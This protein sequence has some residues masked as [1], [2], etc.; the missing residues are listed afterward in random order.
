MKRYLEYCFMATLAI[1]LVPVNMYGSPGSG[2]RPDDPSFPTKAEMMGWISDLSTI[3]NN[4]LPGT[5]TDD[6]AREYLIGKF[7]DIGLANVREEIIDYHDGFLYYFASNWGLTVNGQPIPSMY[8]PNTQPTGPG[9]IS[10][11]VVYVGTSV[12]PDEDVAGKIVL[13]DIEMFVLSLDVLRFFAY[14]GY[15]PRNTTLGLEHVAPW[16]RENF[17]GRDYITEQI[18]LGVY[19]EAVDGGAIGFIGVTENYPDDTP[20]YYG[21]YDN[22]L[23]DIPGLWVSKQKGEDIKAIIA[24]ETGQASLVLEGGVDVSRE[25]ANVIG[26]L[27]G[28]SDDVIVVGTHHDSPWFGA[29]ED[30]SGV[31]EVLALAKFYSQV[32]MENR[33]KKMIF[34]LQAG[35]F[36]NSIGGKH[37]LENNPKIADRIVTELHVEHIA[38]DMDLVDGEWVDTGYPET[39]AMF[40]TGN[41][42]LV[43][44]S[45]YAFEKYD[46][47]R[48]FTLQTETPLRVPHDGAMY[49]TAGFPS[50]G[51]ISGPEWLIH[52]DD[53]LDKVADDELVP[54]AEALAEIIETIQETPVSLILSSPPMPPPLPPPFPVYPGPGTLY[55]GAGKLQLDGREYGGDGGL[56]YRP[57]YIDTIPVLGEFELVYIGVDSSSWQGPW[58][59]YEKI[60]QRRRTILNCQDL[61]GRSLTVKIRGEYVTAVGDGVE[62]EG[63]SGGVKM[64]QN[65]RFKNVGK[66]RGVI[67]REGMTPKVSQDSIWPFMR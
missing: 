62:F 37:F 56:Y 15:D 38:K 54:V 30:G 65:R 63:V 40:A 67:L 49:Y 36:Y 14:N 51:Y 1:A 3:G 29:V 33:E 47:I 45:G 58:L 64:Y 39:R 5:S 35:H 41:P 27:P 50:L 48:S 18:D 46:L 23:K 21:P 8:I 6:E 28:M 59:V 53:S 17:V 31:A 4:R 9:G 24:A 22:L 19:G 11:E 16:V 34:I 26:E 52:S 60:E 32:E 7:N 2:G 10:A 42:F 57:P 43:A 61:A 55:E 12:D 20:N 44:A 66:K 25:T 13:A